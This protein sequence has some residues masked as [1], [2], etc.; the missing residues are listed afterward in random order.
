MELD[1]TGLE[2]RDRELSIREEE[3]NERRNE[4]SEGG[5]T[6]RGR[7]TGRGRGRGKGAKEF[8]AVASN[9][10]SHGR[11]TVDPYFDEGDYIPSSEEKPKPRKRNEKYYFYYR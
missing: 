2:E 7:G 6:Q 11:A 10:R 4:L 8:E 5:S 9:T 1:Q 3:L